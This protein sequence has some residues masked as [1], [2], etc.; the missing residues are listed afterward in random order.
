MAGGCH[1]GNSSSADDLGQRGVC[2]VECPTVELRNKLEVVFLMR[3]MH[4]SEVSVRGG[5]PNSLLRGFREP[6]LSWGR[7]PFDTSLMNGSI[8]KRWVELRTR[9]WTEPLFHG[10]GGC[11]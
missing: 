10:S 5:T 1:F 8:S 11:I 4:E 3:R 7:T 2:S 9:L 6:L